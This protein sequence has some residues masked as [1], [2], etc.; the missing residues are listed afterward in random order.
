MDDSCDAFATFHRGIC[1]HW[2]CAVHGEDESGHTCV[3][4]PGEEG[5][6]A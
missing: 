1:G 3:L 6:E 4:E 2:F 5:G